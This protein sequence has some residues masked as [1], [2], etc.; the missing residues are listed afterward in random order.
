MSKFDQGK[1]WV[2]VPPESVGIPSKA[3]LN[4]IDELES[5]ELCMHGFIMIKDG[6]VFAEGYYAPFHA[7]FPHRMFSISKSY[8]SVAIGLLQEEGKLSIDDKICDY[9]PDKLPAVVHPFI[10]ATTIRDMLKMASPHKSTTYKLMDCDDWV[11]TF[12]HV[13]P[14]RY[15]GTSFV[16]DTSASHVLAALVERLSGMPILDYLKVKVFDKLGCTGEFRWLTDPMGVSMGGSGLICTLRDMTRF[17]LMC[18]NDGEYNGRQIVP[19]EYIRDATSKQINTPLQYSIDEQQGY[20]YQF[21]RCRNN[22]FAMYGMGGQ[23]AICLPDYNFILTT[24]A[25]NQGIPYGIHGIYTALWNN[26]L[27]YLKENNC[28]TADN[29]SGEELK[30]RLSK[31]E[32]KAVKGSKTSPVV[33]DIKGK[34]YL[35]APNQMGITE[36]RLDFTNENEGVFYYTNETGDHEIPFGIGHNKQHIYPDINLMS[37]SSAAW[38]DDKML[39]LRSYIIDQLPGHV[40]MTLTF[41]NNTITIS[42]KK[43]AEDALRRYE[44]FASGEIKAR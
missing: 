5:E 38:A 37:I 40:S 6:K 22:G 27:P 28:V 24:I 13:E 15:P 44:G 39:H 31:L 9:F 25:D 11:K 8:T 29:A 20:G 43:I 26:I 7:D 19:R 30:D 12:F 14:V 17:A 32:V 2:V 16:Y 34:S 10:A 23:L 18:M 36:C 21:W 42:M 41:I 1:N 35:L 3:V 33:N 4:F